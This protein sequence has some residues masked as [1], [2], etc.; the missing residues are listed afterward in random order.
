MQ[1][2]GE[3]DLRRRAA[4]L[5]TALREAQAKTYEITEEL[6]RLISGEPGLGEQMRRL[7]RVFDALWCARYAP[8]ETARYVWNYKRDRPGLKKLIRRLAE[9]DIEN[10][11]ALY[12][13]SADPYFVKNRHTFGLFV[14]SIN[15]WA[16]EGT[17]PDELYDCYHMPP[18]RNDAEHTKRHILDLRKKVV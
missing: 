5:L 17:Q 8:G 4:V 13:Q 9:T 18:C 15:Q 10:R 1:T 2:M 14:G 3:A 7:E 11:M 16:P 12:I 6:E